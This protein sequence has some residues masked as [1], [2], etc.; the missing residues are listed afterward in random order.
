MP[1]DLE[2]LRIDIES[3]FVLSA[4]GRI[5]CVNDPGRTIAPRMFFAGCAQANL[6]HVRADIDGDAAAKLLAI[7]AG[8]SPWRDPWALPQCFGK[9]L[10]VLSGAPFAIGP[11]SRVPLTVAPH[12]IW[13]LPNRLKYEHPATIVRGDSEEGAKLIARFQK[14]GMPQPMLDAGFMSVADLWEPWCLAME[15]EE[16]AAS[17]IAARL[18]A[19]AAEIGVYTF[20]KF[21]ARGFAAAVTAA[22]SSLASLDGRALFYST[23]RANRSSQRVTARLGLRMIGGSFSIG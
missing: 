13:Q 21:R 3:M 14:D 6:A 11:A 22:W 17:A 2:L 1:D 12:L 4:T 20:P 8:E 18:S 23:S 19:R 10:D 7:A 5:E 16:V 15:G 9:L